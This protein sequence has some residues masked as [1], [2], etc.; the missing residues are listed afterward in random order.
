MKADKRYINLLLFTYARI[1]D[2]SYFKILG[3]PVYRRVGYK[4]QIFFWLLKDKN[5]FIA[6]DLHNMYPNFDDKKYECSENKVISINEI[7][8]KVVVYDNGEKI[9]YPLNF[10]LKYD[11]ITIIEWAKNDS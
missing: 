3:I 6:D 8:G 11:G 4:K 9:L 10:Y 2:V 1:G 5:D 7:L